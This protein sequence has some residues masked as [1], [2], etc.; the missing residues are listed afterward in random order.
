MRRGDE[1]MKKGISIWGFAAGTSVRDAIRTAKDIGYEAIELAQNETGETS[2]ESSRDEI[3]SIVQFADETGIAI[4]SFASGLYWKYSLTSNDGEVRE[5]ARAVCRNQLDIASWLGVDAVL[6]VPGAVH[7]PWDSSAEVVPYD[8]A[9]D[10]A[11]EAM[12]ELAADAEKHK[13]TIGVENVWNGMLMSPLEMRDFIDK[14]GS[15]YVA[16]YFDVG[17]V[18]AFGMP[19]H[20]IPILGDRIKRVHVKDFKWHTMG[21]G[22]FVGLLEGDVNWPEVMKAFRDIGYDG[23]LI[24]EL[25]AYTH[26]K[27]AMLRHTLT[28]LESI[29]TM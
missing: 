3:E 22:S 11:L 12:K 21:M 19:E 2:L 29:A 6:V 16:A 17:N 14:V 18:L 24:A 15:E 13:V 7:I 26:D 1:H 9:Y 10:R 5:K 20:W 25:S 4:T 8:L 23:P 28:S 27:E